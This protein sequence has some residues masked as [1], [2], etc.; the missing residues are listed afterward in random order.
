MGGNIISF[1]ANISLCKSEFNFMM[2]LIK[3]KKFNLAKILSNNGM[4]VDA[5]NN[6]QN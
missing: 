4:Y 3:K 2:G 1:L 5:L 6:T